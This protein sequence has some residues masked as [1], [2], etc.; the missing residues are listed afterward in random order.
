MYYFLLYKNK[1]SFLTIRVFILREENG[2]PCKFSLN[3]TKEVKMVK[4]EKKMA[5]LMN[6]FLLNLS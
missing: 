1:F 2:E 6:L 3:L 4:I 5:Q